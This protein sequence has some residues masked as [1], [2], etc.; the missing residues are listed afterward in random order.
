MI[1]DDEAHVFIARRHLKE[2][3]GADFDFATVG[4]ATEGLAELVRG[5][6]DV[7]LVDY[8]IGGADGVELIREAVARG[9][10]APMVMLTGCG[11][12]E[13]ELRA[14]EAGADIF[15]EKERMDA[16]LLER[17]IRLAVDRYRMRRELADRA[18][19]LVCAKKELERSN[20]ELEQFD[21]VASTI[22]ASRSG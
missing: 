1:D 13:L 22:S 10:D 15:L 9:C 8:R 17:A 2:V 4:S 12:R 19:E 21:Y 16:T 14:M 18:R 3:E 20:A 11:S 6:H 7:Y 5:A